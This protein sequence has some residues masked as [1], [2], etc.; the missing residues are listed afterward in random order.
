MFA[1]GKE[2]RQPAIGGAV[3]GIGEE[4]HA[5]AQVEPRADDEADAGIIGRLVRADEAGDAVA[6][7][8]RDRREAE[9]GGSPDQLPRMR[10]AAQE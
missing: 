9:R 1:E 3:L 6:V 5:V 2:R 8:D 7:S 4:A 10:A